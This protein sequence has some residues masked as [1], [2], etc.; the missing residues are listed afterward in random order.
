M[1]LHFRRDDPIP[2]SILI[3]TALQH[4]LS[5]CTFLIFPILVGRA[6]GMPDGD[7]P[8]FLS[9]TLISLGIA[10][11]F[12]AT[13]ALG[14][15]YLCPA[16]MTSAYLSPSLVAARFGGLP[17]VFSMTFFSGAIEA[18]LSRFPTGLKFL[19]PP[20][21]L[22]SSF[23]LSVPQMP[24]PVSRHCFQKAMSLQ[25]ILWSLSSRLGL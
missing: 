23:S 18:T 17:L 19:S 3:T 10:N 22:A 21:S 7:L 20:D 11:L 16:G 1:T 5:L 2:L 14:S 15:G 6:A 25:P 8:A 24:S 9:T 12:Q 13:R 4:V